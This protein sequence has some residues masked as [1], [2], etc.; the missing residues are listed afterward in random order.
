MVDL[1]LLHLQI[2]FIGTFFDSR[3]EYEPYCHYYCIFQACLN[4]TFKN[5][6]LTHD[7]YWTISYVQQ[8]TPS[9]MMFPEDLN[10]SNFKTIVT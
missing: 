2:I 1:A 3:Q 9:L 10:S 8:N 7:L 4:V 6:H 5:K